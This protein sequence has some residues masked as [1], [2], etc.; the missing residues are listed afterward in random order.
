MR[1]VVGIVLIVIQV[2]LT[3]TTIAYIV[4]AEED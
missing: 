3:S 4:L 1:T 2:A